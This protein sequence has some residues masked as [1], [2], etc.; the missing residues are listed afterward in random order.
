MCEKAEVA[1]VDDLSSY[2]YKGSDRIAAEFACVEY[3]RETFGI[4]RRPRKVSR[5]SRFAAVK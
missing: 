3:Y 1:V 5:R 4:W 2:S